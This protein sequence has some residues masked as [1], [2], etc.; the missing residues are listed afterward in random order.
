MSNDNQPKVYIRAKNADIDNKFFFMD[1]DIAIVSN[2]EFIKQSVLYFLNEN[3]NI[4]T[5]DSIDSILKKTKN[6]VT[7]IQKLYILTVT[8]KNF[9]NKIKG[10][11][12]PA[13]GIPP[14]P[15]KKAS[16]ISEISLTST[17]PPIPPEPQKK[18]SNISEISLTSTAPPIPPNPP[19]PDKPNSHFN[20]LFLKKLCLD[21]IILL[22]NINNF[23]ER[24]KGFKN[25][26]VE[27]NELESEISNLK[28][29]KQNFE[30]NH[31]GKKNMDF[32]FRSAT[33]DLNQYGMFELTADSPPFNIIEAIFKI[34]IIPMYYG[35]TSLKCIPPT[36]F[37]IFHTG[38]NAVNRNIFEFKISKNKNKINKLKTDNLNIETDNRDIATCISDIKTEIEK[39]I[40]DDID[41]MNEDINKINFINPT[42]QDFKD[43]YNDFMNYIHDIY[44]I[45]PFDQDNLDQDYLFSII[46]VEYE[47][48]HDYTDIISTTKADLQKLKQELQKLKLDELVIMYKGIFSL[49]D[50]TKVTIE[51]VLIDAIINETKADLQKLK[52]ELQKLKRD[53][54][55][56]M[57]KGIFSLP[58]STE[59]TAIEDVLIDAIINE[60]KADLQKLKREL[61]KLKRDELVIMYKG[62]FSLPDSTKVTIE[63]VLIDAIINET[64]V[65]EIIEKIIYPRVDEAYLQK[66]KQELQKL[67]RD[68]LVIMYKGIFSLPDSTEVTAIE[69]VLIDEII[70]ETKADLQK[71]KRELQK[72]KRD[73]LVIMYKG[74]FSLPDSTEVTAIKD[75]LI[76]AIINETKVPEIIEKIIYPSDSGGAKNKKRTTIK[77]GHTLLRKTKHTNRNKIYRNKIYRNTKR[78]RQTNTKRIRQ[79]KKR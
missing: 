41:K 28:Y 17:A 75:V 49:P 37:G 27:V 56:I 22:K 53:E 44:K 65:P 69:D 61:Q 67:K 18:A 63:D 10:N 59:V 8:Y 64:K 47:K 31:F 40:E 62:I 45:K 43:R 26:I 48:Y 46:Y 25:I 66:L 58:D 39:N 16:N 13:P 71:L 14:E 79:T 11:N 35:I 76:D 32:N 15:Q 12:D 38:Y 72:L 20:D 51:D 77:S 19:I 1:L 50:S 7:S 73:E 4:Y 78:I 55:V 2:I 9:Y 24:L 21:I 60:T 70:N 74:I 6:I 30:K 33:Y 42:L 3:E 23:W 57:Y 34:V 36:T 5:I 29:E 52:R 54:L 68:E